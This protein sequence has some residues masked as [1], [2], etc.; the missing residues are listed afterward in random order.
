MLPTRSRLQSWNP[1]SLVPAAAAIQ[2][3]GAAVYQAVRDLDDRI[4]RMPRTGGW[5][6]AAHRAAAGMFSRATDRSSAFKTYAE[7]VASALSDGS[8]AI[9]TARTAALAMAAQIDSG[10]L[11]VTDQWVVL[12]DPAGMSAER[13]AELEILA[14]IAQGELN[15]L[16]IAVDQ[17]DD[18]TSMKI[19]TT[20]AEEGINSDLAGPVAPGPAPVDEV[21]SPATAE[22]EQFQEVARAEDMATTVREITDTEDLT[23]NRV[24][25]YTMMDGSTQVATE[26]IDQG[27][28]SQQ[29]YPPGTTRVLH[30]DKHGNWISDTMTTPLDDGGVKTSVHWSDGTTVTM[31][32]TADGVRTGSC[33]TADG[34]ES[35]LPDEFFT[36]PFP[37]LVGGALS[38]LETKAGQGI[39]ALTAA[40]LDKVKTGA[41]WGGPA[42]GVATMAYNMVSAETLHDAC[43]AGVSGVYSTVGGIATAAAGGA[44]FGPVGAFVGSLGGSWAF[45]YVGSVVGEVLCPR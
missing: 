21:P 13:V 17:A 41:K 38:G 28:P 4:D 22:G 26:Y 25:T 15:P 7:A 42:I 32:E 34:R 10:P 3:A 16:V 23:G 33:I 14:Q 43:V 8:G 18:T 1:E 2:A 27:L 36:D 39:P 19:V 5:E 24:T 29:V 6:G 9:S 31:S 11:N 12:I 30:T 35:P 40:E 37:T 20:V 45:G 44:L